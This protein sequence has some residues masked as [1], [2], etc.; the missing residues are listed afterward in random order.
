MTMY[1]KTTTSLGVRAPLIL[2]LLSALAPLTLPS[3]G[4]NANDGGGGLGTETG[5]PPVIEKAK[6]HLEVMPDGVHLI[7]TAGAVTP[8]VE[9][10]VT[11]QRTGEN[12]VATA[13]ADGSVDVLVPGAAADTYEVTVARGG[14]ETSITLTSADLPSDLSTVSCDALRAGGFGILDPIYAS[15]D[16]ACTDDSDCVTGA[17]G[18]GTCIPFSCGGWI[19]SVAGRDAAIA[20]GSQALM[21]MCGEFEARDC[22]NPVV[23]CA[24]PPP[25]R[26]VCEQ[27]QCLAREL[28]CG[29]LSDEANGQRQQAIAAAARNCDI[30]ADCVLVRP[31][32][33]CVSDCGY[34]EP[35]SIASTA[36]AALDAQIQQTEQVACEQ[37]EQELCAPPGLLDCE[38]VAE[39]EAVCLQG[40]CELR[41][42]VE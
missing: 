8:G 27:G 30:N 26:L 40:L 17:F 23:D 41:P 11:N 19:A 1:Q 10:R 34:G 14:R 42:V 29:D 36:S 13:A 33:S 25:R 3:C 16:K 31:R 18:S 39:V 38:A 35:A 15:A 12:A 6:L 7:G 4:G 20:A 24:P 28:S 32:L 9:V 22:E 21:A 2:A 5:N 37:F